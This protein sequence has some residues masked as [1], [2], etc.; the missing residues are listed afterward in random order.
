MKKSIYDDEYRELIARLIEKRKSKGI[1]QKQLAEKM[2]I[3]NTIIS[4]AENC[5]RRLDVI[6]LLNICRALDI[7]LSDILVE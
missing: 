7:K 2:G 4:K 5:V 1:T 3:D 6:E